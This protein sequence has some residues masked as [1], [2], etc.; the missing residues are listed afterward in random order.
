MTKVVCFT[1]SPDLLGLIRDEYVGKALVLDLG[2][3]RNTLEALKVKTT[4]YIKS[5]LPPLLKEGGL[6]IVLG[7]K[8]DSDV[9]TINES[10]KSAVEVYD[11]GHADD[12]SMDNIFSF[13]VINVTRITHVNDKAFLNAIGH[14][15]TQ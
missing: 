14:V 3:V 4:E 11:L 5:N 15:L 10:A 7:V 13:F 6:V 12:F 2:A 9:F 8:G 1:G